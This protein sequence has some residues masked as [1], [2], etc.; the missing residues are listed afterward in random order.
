M[1]TNRGMSCH[2]TTVTLKYKKRRHIKLVF[3]VHSLNSVQYAVFLSLGLG[4]FLNGLRLF[5]FYLL[6][7]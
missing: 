5:Q 7:F 6:I 3:S 1:V 4:T 2:E